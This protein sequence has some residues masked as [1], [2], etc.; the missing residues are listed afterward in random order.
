MMAIIIGLAVYYV[1]YFAT[2]AAGAYKWGCENALYEA[3]VEEWVSSGYADYSK[4]PG[5]RYDRRYFVHWVTES[6]IVPITIVSAFFF[7]GVIVFIV[8]A[9]N[10]M[11]WIMLG[12]YKVFSWVVK[13]I[14]KLGEQRG[15][16]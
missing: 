5:Q 8:A 6:D 13:S 14:I 12:C 4:H 7:P 9:A 16:K 1:L 10:A 2:L 15:C 11:Y 3:R